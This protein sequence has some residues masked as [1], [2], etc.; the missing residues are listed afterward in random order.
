MR[1]GPEARTTENVALAA[2]V[3]LELGADWVKVPYVEGFRQVTDACF[4]PVVIMGGS[5]RSHE[6]EIL[7]E[8]RAAM[9]A[10]ASG[11][12]IGRNIFEADDPEAMTAALSAIIHQD[13]S[14]EQALAILKR[15]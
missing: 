8:V 13:A 1:C 15:A 3:G 7:A 11:A 9:D 2:R 6:A 5:R 4:K 12:T 10:G 14:V